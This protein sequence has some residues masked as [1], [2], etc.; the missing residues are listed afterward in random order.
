MQARKC[1]PYQLIRILPWKMRVPL[2]MHFLNK[3]LFTMFHSIWG[4]TLSSNWLS[5]GKN[6]K[7]EP[8]STKNL[9]KLKAKR[10]KINI[11]KLV[12]K[13]AEKKRRRRYQICRRR[14]HPINQV[15]NRNRLWPKSKLF[16]RPRF[17]HCWRGYSRNYLGKMHKGR[18]M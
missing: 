8:A 2:P 7:I 10:K 16:T 11:G 17:V 9:N 13:E 3:D 12:G 15:E 6:L 18:W 5:W 4:I 1:N 14:R